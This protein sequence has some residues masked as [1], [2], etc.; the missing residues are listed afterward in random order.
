MEH[1]WHTFFALGRSELYPEQIAALVCREYG[2]T[3]EEYLGQPAWFITTILAMLT[4]EAE[5][6]NRRNKR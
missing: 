5:E 3:W 2:W 6:M 1:R 4:L